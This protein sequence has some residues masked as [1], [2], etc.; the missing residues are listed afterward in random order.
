[1]FLN[2]ELE[3]LILEVGTRFPQIDSFLSDMS[4]RTRLKS[5]SF[6]SPTSLP[7]SFT[8]LLHR[9]STLEKLVLVAPG[10]L[11][12]G[13]GK[14]ASGLPKLHTLQLDLTGRSV[15][16]VEGFFDDIP[17]QDG[18]ATPSVDGSS[19]SGVFSEEDPEIDFTEI[20]KSSLRLTGD[21]PGK[22]AFRSCETY[23]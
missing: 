19:D 4:S 20:K 17:A 23:S 6:S 13:V 15:I 11:S 9:Q 16:A 1:M 3:E 5:F 10:A 21:L 22:A 2:P 8:E 14:W 18:Y 12:P 7:D